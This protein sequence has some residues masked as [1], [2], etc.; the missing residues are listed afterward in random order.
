MGSQCKAL[1]DSTL[2]EQLDSQALH[3]S[4]LREQLH[5]STLRGQLDTQACSHTAFMNATLAI[6]TRRLQQ[7]SN[8][9]DNDKL[10]PSSVLTAQVELPTEE[11]VILDFV[12][13]Q[14]IKV[15]CQAHV[16]GGD[17]YKTGCPGLQ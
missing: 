16:R 17:P 5:D 1:H 8:N 15:H 6:Y 10:H 14:R 13:T 7:S 2:R 11:G 4:T 9:C 3:D 12:A